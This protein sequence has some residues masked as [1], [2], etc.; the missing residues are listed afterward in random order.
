MY[1]VKLLYEFVKY[2]FLLIS[3][4]NQ[5]LLE[6]FLNKH[7]PFFRLLVLV[8]QTLI[9]RRGKTRNVKESL[10]SQLR[11]SFALHILCVAF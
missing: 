8:V 7:F 1:E 2:S 6:K 4:K 10:D 11:L 3:M 5:V 9:Q